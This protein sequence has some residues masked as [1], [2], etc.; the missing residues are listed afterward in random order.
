MILHPKTLDLF[1]G[2]GGSNYGAHLAG[3]QIVA[4]VDKWNIAVKAYRAN[5]PES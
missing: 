4:G 1:C 5:F 2:A 3:A